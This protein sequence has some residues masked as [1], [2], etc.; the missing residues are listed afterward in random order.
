[1]VSRVISA[2]RVKKHAP[3]RCF[4]GFSGLVLVSDAPNGSNTELGAWREK[5]RVHQV[6]LLLDTKDESIIPSGS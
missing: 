6:S 5:Q 4:S 2:E 3:K 1:V